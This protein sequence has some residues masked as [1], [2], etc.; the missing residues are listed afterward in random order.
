MNNNTALNAFVLTV[1]L[2]A[3]TLGIGKSIARWNTAEY[4][5]QFGPVQ[6]YTLPTTP[7]TGEYTAY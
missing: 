3:A 2:A 7:A 5:R 4:N 6:V 1:G